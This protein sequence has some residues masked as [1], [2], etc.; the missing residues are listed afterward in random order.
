MVVRDSVRETPVSPGSRIDVWW[1]GEPGNI[2]LML[3][4][5]HLLRR[6]PDW[7]SNTLVIKM[8]VTSED[9]RQPAEAKMIEFI[10]DARIGR[11][12]EHEVLVAGDKPPFEVIAASSC[13]AKLVFLGMRTP[14]EN[15]TDAL[16]ADY[17]RHILEQTEDLPAT[18]LVIA[19]GKVNLD[20]LFDEA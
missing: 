1:A 5:A 11:S 19:S 20:A 18:A 14:E 6:T 10:N 15:E 9:K 12:V 17:Y 3:A 16:Y 4:L 8:I 2:G 7:R 13:D